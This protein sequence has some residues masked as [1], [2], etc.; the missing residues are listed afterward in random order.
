MANDERFHPL[1]EGTSAALFVFDADRILYI[2]PASR[3]LTGY[4]A[5]EL[6]DRPFVALLHPRFRSRFEDPIAKD[7]FE[8]EQIQINRKKGEPLWIE[9]SLQPI[10]F[11][12]AA[13]T[14]ATAVDIHPLKESDLARRDAEVQLKLVQR[15]GRT[16]SWDWR[17]STD[18]LTVYGLPK[19][20]VIQGAPA[21]STTGKA[22]FNYLPPDDLVHLKQAVRLS[23]R[24]REPLFVEV[25]LV[26]LSGQTHWLVLRGQAVP[27]DTGEREHLVG[28]ATDITERRRA[29]QVLVQEQEYS[30]AMLASISDGVIR[31]DLEGR[32][33]DLSAPAETIIGRSLSEARN[34]FLREMVSF[35]DQETG[36]TLDDPIEQ[37]LMSNSPL[38]PAQTCLVRPRDG[39]DVPVQFH[40]AVLRDHCSQEIGVVLVMKDMLE[41]RQFER[42]MVYLATHDPLT[43]LVNRTEFECRLGRCMAE[44]RRSQRQDSVLYLDLDGFKLINDTFGHPAGDKML[45]QFASFLKCRFRETDTLGRIG[46]DKFGVLL[47]SCPPWQT[48]DLVEKLYKDLRSFRFEWDGTSLPVS[49]STGLASISPDETQVEKVLGVAEDACYLAKQRGGDR[50]YEFEPTELA[51]SERHTQLEILHQI[52]ES[53]R[54][55]SF[56]LQ[57]QL[58]Q[59]VVAPESDP[60]MYE[61]LLRIPDRGDTA[62]M[63]KQFMPVAERHSIVSAIDRWV[64]THSLEAVTGR[65][66]VD[67]VRFC[68]NISAHS[69]SDDRFLEFVL[70]ELSYRGVDPRSIYFEISETAT[71][72]NFDKA[73]KF[74]SVLRSRGCGFVLDNFGSGLSSFAYLRNFPVDFIKIDGQ[75]V[76]NLTKDPTQRALVESINHVGHVMQIRTIAEAIESQESLQVIRQMKVD[77]AQGDGISQPVSLDEVVRQRSS[78]STVA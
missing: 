60:D 26:D 56:T 75:F 6:L 27:D 43:D 8:K 17:V 48:R 78:R 67:D 28:V 45:K 2:N 39:E 61:I 7:R 13:A 70:H 42:G 29:E 24:E 35:V 15:A 36:A 72:A 12:G 66:L 22:F 9:L 51:T 33:I 19:D 65:D 11:R 23:L 18:E 62:L 50:F 53:L 57:A 1:V 31:T 77:Y 5:R 68:I 59:P 76:Q 34:H 3:K 49:L 58:I 4:S 30:L 38:S 71:V 16:V 52:Q 54:N 32:I 37:S 69:L 73:Q 10:L 14:L 74:I 44:T 25:S 20:L 46:G 41:Q 40:T 64:L 47:E 63:P 21:L 55:G